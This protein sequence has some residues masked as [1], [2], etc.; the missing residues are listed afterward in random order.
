LKKILIMVAMAMLSSTQI[1]EVEAANPVVI[2]KTNYGDIA[3]EL[4]IE[5]APKT[6][7]NFLNYVKDGF[8]DETIFHRVIKGFMI[9][10]GGLTHA[11]ERKKTKSP[12]SNEADN[13][14]KN[15]RGT[16]AMART[17]DPHSA[18]SQFFINT[19][20]NPFLD[21]KNKTIKGWGYCV[22]GKVAEGMNV[23]EEI[24]HVPTS[25]KGTLQNVP[26]TAIIIKQA[27]IKIFEENPKNK[28]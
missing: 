5:K 19:V 26:T 2:L 22:F 11:L 16:I 9:Q 1:S 6:V 8:Y 12:V 28:K 24:E 14:L 13:A 15:L 18:T 17:M 23:V 10:G 7:E 4:Y 25:E 21:Y 27:K 3:L 20:D